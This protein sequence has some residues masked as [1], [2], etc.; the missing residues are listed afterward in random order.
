MATDPTKNKVD[1]FNKEDN[2]LTSTS[3]KGG[4]GVGQGEFHTPRYEPIPIRKQT[5]TEKVINNEHNA[6]IVLG[7]DRPAS[8]GSGYGARPINGTACID[9][10]V[11]MMAGAKTGPQ[12]KTNVDPNFA[13]DAARIYISQKTD[14]DQNFGLA[15]GRKEMRRENSTKAKSGI[16]IK[17][18]GVRIIARENGIKL[19]T[20]KGNF[21]NT[22]LG[23][24]KNSRGE[25]ITPNDLGGIELIVGNDTTEI[26]LSEI[27][28]EPI[29]K[30]LNLFFPIKLP[31]KIKRLQ[32]M[33]KGENLIL[34]FNYLL[35]I[36]DSLNTKIN[37]FSQFFNDLIAA[38]QTG[39]TILP[40][41]AAFAATATL[42]SGRIFS[43][44]NIGTN[45]QNGN[46]K[47]MLNGVELNFLNPA[48]QFY[49][50]SRY[51]RL[52]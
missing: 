40:T 15:P 23:G 19:V 47:Q 31:E 36:I 9:L 38:I 30:L 39:I 22:G 18:D 49:I 41:S 12:E 44:I 2:T 7:R 21:I 29:L 52:T 51:C 10:C 25:S 1:G 11:G 34:C 48:G 24:E 8:I 16:G 46:I 32:S 37:M 35:N 50:N 26:A 33:V 4:R 20:G 42:I 27:L 28:T 14:I 6:W 17:A 43:E 5:P 13:S 45:P 3:S